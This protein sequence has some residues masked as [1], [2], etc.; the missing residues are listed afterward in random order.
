MTCRDKKENGKFTTSS[1][2]LEEK[3]AALALG[4]PCLMLV[5]DGIDAREIGGL[6]GDDQRLPFNRNNF[7]RIVADALRMLG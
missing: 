6:Q 2:L 7:T 1:W 5:E 3:G 4:K